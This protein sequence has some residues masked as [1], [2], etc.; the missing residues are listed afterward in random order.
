MPDKYFD[1]L[2]TDRNFTLNAGYEP[3][4]AKNQQSIGQDIQHAIIESGLATELVAER[5][6]TLRY[7]VFTKII[8]LVETDR[9]IIPG[10]ARIKEETSERL[11]LTADTYDF[12]KIGVAIN[13]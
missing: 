2:I 8:L 6:P 3:N 4:L 12:G 10:T 9:R 1:L 11:Y 13:G 5:S 7:D